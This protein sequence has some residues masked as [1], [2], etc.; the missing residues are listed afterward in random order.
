MNEMVVDDN[1]LRSVVKSKSDMVLF[2]DQK[3]IPEVMYE[4]VCKEDY[5]FPLGGKVHFKANEPLKVNGLFAKQIV[6][7]TRGK[8]QF[9]DKDLL[10]DVVADSGRDEEIA[11]NNAEIAELKATV[12]AL[13]DKKEETV[14]KTKAKAKKED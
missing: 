9:V 1:A 12:K 13:L 6:K 8:V 4:L 3:I 11:K 5:V 10:A 2:K 14:P 7:Q